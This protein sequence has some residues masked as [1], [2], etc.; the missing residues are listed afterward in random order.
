MTAIVDT[1]ASLCVTPDKDNFIFYHT[2]T[3]RVL[4]GLTKGVTIADV[5]TVKWNVEVNGHVVELK[6]RALQV[7]E[8]EMRL[9]S[10]QQLK[11]EHSPTIVLIAVEA[12]SVTNKFEEGALCCLCNDSNLPKMQLCTPTN[13][14]HNLQAL[15]ACIM[16]ESNQNLTTSQKELLKWHWHLE[17]ALCSRQPVTLTS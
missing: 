13:Q 4:K 9:L 16:A 1:G 2:E 17:Q 11:K 10:P 3:G 15:N 14:E 8:C 12:H 6:L 7:P 5:G